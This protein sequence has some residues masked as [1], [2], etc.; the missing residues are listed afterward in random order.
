M[1]RSSATACSQRPREEAHLLNLCV[2]PE[3]RREGLGRFLLEHMLE[4]A[5]AD[6]AQRIFLEVRPSNHAARELYRSTR[7]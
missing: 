1:R 6:G 4:L 3:R 7:F 5:R 2:R